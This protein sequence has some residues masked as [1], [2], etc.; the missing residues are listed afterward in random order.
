M[1]CNVGGNHLFSFH[2]KVNSIS[3]LG[4]GITHKNSFKRTRGKFRLVR[5]IIL[6]KC[7]ATKY[8]RRERKY[9]TLRVESPKRNFTTKRG[10]GKAINEVSRGEECIRVLVISKICRCFR[11]ATPFC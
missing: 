3:F 11:S 4:L 5:S 10:G 6:H 8:P 1:E 2:G 7:H 9:I